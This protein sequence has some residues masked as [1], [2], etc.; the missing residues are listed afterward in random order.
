[1]KLHLRKR[2]MISHLKNDIAIAISVPT[3]LDLTKRI[4]DVIQSPAYNVK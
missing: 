3:K 1:M 2:R 4:E